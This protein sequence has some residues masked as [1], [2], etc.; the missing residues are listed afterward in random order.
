MK[1]KEK[2]GGSKPLW[3]RNRQP[4]ISIDPTIKPKTWSDMVKNKA[5]T[6]SLI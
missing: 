6:E 5:E 4:K 1:L 3:G 2:G